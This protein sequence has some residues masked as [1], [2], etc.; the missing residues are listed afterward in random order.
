MK[1]LIALFALCAV[2]GAQANSGG[3]DKQGCHVDHKTGI[4]HCH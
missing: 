1:T 3:T 4:K 2:L